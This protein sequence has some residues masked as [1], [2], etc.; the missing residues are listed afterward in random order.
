MLPAEEGSPRSDDDT[1]HAMQYR[2]GDGA[3]T[4]IRNYSG[5]DVVIDV[6]DD[7]DQLTQTKQRVYVPEAG[8]Q[9]DSAI[10]EI[11]AC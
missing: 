11:E 2:I 4:T 10:A 8:D 6:A 7:G 1:L 5:V 9:A 3:W